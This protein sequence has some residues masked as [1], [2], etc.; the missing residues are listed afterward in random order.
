LN[1][2]LKNAHLLSPEDGLD[3]IGD[4]LIE[5]G[6]IKEIRKSIKHSKSIE[7]IDLTGKT[8]VPGLY[9]MH[10]HFREPGQTHKENLNTGAEAAA[11]GGFTGVLCM[12]NTSPAIDNAV[13][14]KDLVAKSNDNLVDINFSVC[15]TKN[16]KGEELSPILSLKDAGAVAITDDGSPISDPEILRRVFEYGSQTGLPVIQHCE[17]MRLSNKGVMNEGFISTVTGMRGIPSVSETSVIARDIEIC[18]YVNGA[19]YHIQHISCGGSVRLL[20]SAKAR[21][22]SVTG[23]ACPHHFILTDKH[24]LD[25]DTNFKMNPPLRGLED[26]EEILK[27]LADGT[28]DVICT[29]HAPHTEYEKSQGFYDVPFGIIGL[30]TAF[31]L[32]YTYLVRRDIIC[33]KEL[34][35]KMSV[36]PRR[37]LGLDDVRIEPG[38]IANLSIFDLNSRWTVKKGKSKSKSRNTPFD[39]FRLHGKPFMVINKGKKFFSEL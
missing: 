14:L 29:D 11:N 34:L 27:G 2:V 8:V 23:E 9:D 35:M 13:L 18:S 10:V 22:V 33:F 19:H 16:R 26:V 24:C 30:E 38:V 20:R 12:P 15:A 6:V 32:A 7:S 28:I 21:G 5:E 3:L 4:L 36:N 31:G 37:I 1:I 39:G 25:Y 17:D